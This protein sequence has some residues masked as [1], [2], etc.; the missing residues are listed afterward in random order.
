LNTVLT[1]RQ[2]QA[3]SHSKRGWEVFTDAAVRALSKQRQGL[4]FLLW[5]RPAQEKVRYDETECSAYLRRPFL[6]FIRYLTFE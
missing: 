3:N 1:V 4:I 5:G 2:G 6:L